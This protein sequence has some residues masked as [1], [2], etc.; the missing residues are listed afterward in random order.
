M[1]PSATAPGKSHPNSLRKTGNQPGVVRSTSV[2]FDSEISEK[3]DTLAELFVCLF[4]TFPLPVVTV[5]RWVHVMTKRGHGGG[6]LFKCS[7]YSIL[8]HQRTMIISGTRF[9]QEEA[10]IQRKLVTS[11]TLNVPSFNKRCSNTD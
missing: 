5:F 8:F 4:S 11:K 2:M 6:K 9:N 3:G 7:D 1:K 10:I